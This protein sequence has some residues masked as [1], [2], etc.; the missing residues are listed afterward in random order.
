MQV[1]SKVMKVLLASKLFCCCPFS[2]QLYVLFPSHQQMMHT[3]PSPL[4]FQLSHSQLE[5]TGVGD[6]PSM[7]YILLALTK[8]HR[9]TFYVQLATCPA[10]P[11]LV[12][13]PAVVSKHISTPYIR[14]PWFTPL[15]LQ[16]MRKLKTSEAPTPRL[17]FT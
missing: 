13:P 15:H 17:F 16:P 10:K 5:Q 12:S 7:L 14:A 1:E 2:L 6:H 4:H 8:G 9:T 3:G 11:N